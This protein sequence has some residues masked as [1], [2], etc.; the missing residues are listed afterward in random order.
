[1]ETLALDK[2]KR[3]LELADRLLEGERGYTK[4]QIIE[5]MRQ[6]LNIKAD[7]ALKGFEEMLKFEAIKPTSKTNWYYLGSSTPF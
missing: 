4:G 2:H 3:L 1:M 5:I 7:R 6:R